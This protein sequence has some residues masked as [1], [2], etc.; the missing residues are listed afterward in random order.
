VTGPTLG[1]IIAAAVSLIA[2]VFGRPG[3]DIMAVEILQQ[4]N[5]AWRRCLWIIASAAA[6]AGLLL[7][8]ILG[9]CALVAWIQERFSWFTGEGVGAVVGALVGIGIFVAVAWDKVKSIPERYRERIFSSLEAAI[10]EDQRQKLY[11]RK[12]GMLSGRHDQ[13]RIALADL[14][15]HYSR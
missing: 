14:L 7:A 9:I 2:W 12:A 1:L 5:A 3:S 15:T 4:G 13:F 11:E 10:P 6:V 8:V